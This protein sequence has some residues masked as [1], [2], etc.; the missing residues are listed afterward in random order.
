MTANLGEVVGQIREMT[1]KTNNLVSRTRRLLDVIDT[2]TQ[3]VV[4]SI[5][6]VKKALGI[7]EK[8]CP[9]CSIE[10]AHYCIDTCHHLYCHTCCHK[11]LR[12]GK[13]FMCRQDVTAMFKV[14]F[15]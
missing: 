15:S 13:C 6:R 12:A 1:E 5:S 2:Q 11:V 9:I 3:I 10:P 4:E 8:L 7:D 14:F